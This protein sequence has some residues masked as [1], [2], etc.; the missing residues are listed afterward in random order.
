MISGVNQKSLSEGEI[1]KREI[2]LTNNLATSP[3]GEDVELTR[4]RCNE[5]LNNKEIQRIVMKSLC[6]NSR[7]LPRHSQQR[8][9]VTQAN[10][11]S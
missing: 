1:Q 11:T 2:P 8:L 6:C 3:R 4:Y 9:N 7:R 10:S 5:L